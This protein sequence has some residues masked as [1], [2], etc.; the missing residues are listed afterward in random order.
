[1]RREVHT[2]FRR[3]RAVWR[4]VGSR[5]RWALGGAFLLIALTSACHI[6]I[7]LSLGRLIDHAQ[8]GSGQRLPLGALCHVAALDLAIIAV[9]YLV[10]E[11]LNVL[12]RFLVE[13]TCM[14][15]E[16]ETAVRLVSHLL[17]IDLAAFTHQKIGALHGRI[18]RS[19]EG[20]V[21]FLR[22]SLLDFFPALLTGALALAA[23]TSKQPWLGLLMLGV[24]PAALGLTRWQL[25]SQKGV[26]LALMETKEGID[27][28]VVEQLSGLEYVRAANTHAQEVARVARAAEE[29]RARALR[30]HVQMS[31]FGSA[32]A[33]NEAFFH[34]IVLG[35]SVYFAAVGAISFG[36]IWTFSLLF[37]N[38]M[39]PLSDVHRVVDEAQESGLHVDQLLR[40]LA[41]PVDPS[42]APAAVQEPRLEVGRPALAVQDLRVEYRTAAGKHRLGLDGVSLAVGHGETLGVAGRSG[43][44]KSTWLRALLRLTHPCGGRIWLGGVPL[45]S[46]SRET[47]GRLIGYVGQAP[48]VFAGT[49]AENIAYG[50]GPVP[51]EAIES[52]AR[53]ACLHEEILAMPGGYQAPIAERG[54]NLSGGQKQRIALARIFLK[55][56]PILILDEGTS[57]LDTVSEGKIQRAIAAVRQDRTVILVTHRLSTLRH[58]DR[59]VVLEEG[60]IAEVG[61]Y[62]ELVQRGGVF[63]KLVRSTG[64]GQETGG[65]GRESLPYRDATLTGVGCGKELPA[66]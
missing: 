27:G 15:I 22:L 12:R 24:I 51:P 39:T 6:A 59:V 41:E 33:L 10:R 61:T 8:R 54:Q 9:A 7:P 58:T 45:E 46:I 23:T 5:H 19:V 16:K 13:N 32:K 36:D 66:R 56:P 31:L 37:L 57:A 42:F 29:R 26:R 43:G 35:G 48:F 65:L 18:H 20:L 17:K 53:L 34:I 62:L 21:R 52:A 49:V 30:H 40:L 38:V 44:G 63:S 28:T 2:P 64:D 47:I 50:N 14:G 4:L 25:R 3:A 1:L 55:D 60:R 11:F